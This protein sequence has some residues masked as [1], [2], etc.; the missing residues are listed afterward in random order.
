MHWLGSKIPGAMNNM[1]VTEPIVTRAPE[2]DWSGW[3]NW[4]RSHLD[5][6]REALTEAFGEALGVTC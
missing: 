1:Q 5:I 3:E 2:P 4:L 6:Q